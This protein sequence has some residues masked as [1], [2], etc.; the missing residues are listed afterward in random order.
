MRQLSGALIL[1]VSLATATLAQASL[2][3]GCGQRPT[4]SSGLGDLANDPIF[5]HHTASNLLAEAGIGLDRDSLMKA[6]RNDNAKIRE[7][8][9]WQ[10]ADEGDKR[11]IASIAA[12]LEVEK[13]A[14][15]RI[16]LACSLIELGDQRGSESLRLDCGNKRV[17]ILLRLDAAHYLVNLGER[18]C[19]SVIVEAF[20]GGLREQA[21]SAA[22]EFGQL[23]PSEYVEVRDLLLRDE[24]STVR[25]GA[26]DLI[27][28]MNDVTA[29]SEVEAAMGRENNPM[30]RSIMRKLLVYLVAYRENKE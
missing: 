29:I 7:L 12:A 2:N 4:G 1:L 10:L 26:L 30:V 24:Q 8:A 9:A 13:A 22:E 11:S 18:P 21:A 20:Q 19:T 27:R 15:V 5:E 16:N 6:L 3:T 28:D 17:P 14:Q 23:A 25:I